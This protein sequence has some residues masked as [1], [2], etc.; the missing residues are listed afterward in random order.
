MKSTKLETL[1][2]A[3]FVALGLCAIGIAFYFLF[4][5]SQF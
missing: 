3:A 5:R 1:A 4:I 2:A